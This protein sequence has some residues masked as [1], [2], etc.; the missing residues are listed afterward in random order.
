MACVGTW[1]TWM[2]HT[3]AQDVQVPAGTQTVTALLDNGA[4]GGI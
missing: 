1:I 3:I 4:G 2:S